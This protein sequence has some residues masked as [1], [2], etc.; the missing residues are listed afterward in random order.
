MA[1]VVGHL[2]ERHAATVLKR[3]PK[4]GLN[5]CLGDVRWRRRVSYMTCSVIN[6][7]QWRE[8]D[9]PTQLNKSYITLTL[10]V[11]LERAI[12]MNVMQWKGKEMLNIK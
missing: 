9:H 10:A 2:L 6:S 8:I 5:P 12:D 4:V 11:A 7:D 1:G 3:P